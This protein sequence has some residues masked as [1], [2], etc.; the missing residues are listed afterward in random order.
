MFKFLFV[1]IEDLIVDI[2]WCLKGKTIQILDI[3]SHPFIWWSFYFNKPANL[4]RKKTSL[5]INKS[6]NTS[7]TLKI[8]ICWFIFHLCTLCMSPSI[9]STALVHSCQRI[10][11]KTYWAPSNLWR[12]CRTCYHWY[13]SFW[14]LK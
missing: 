5:Q 12:V 13:G 2:S 7:V 10:D 8:C 4:L 1:F 14:F 3:L 11:F 6:F 9:A